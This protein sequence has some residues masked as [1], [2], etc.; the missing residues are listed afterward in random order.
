MVTLQGLSEDVSIIP[1]QL[2]GWVIRRKML[3]EATLPE[4][5]WILVVSADL[6]LRL[7]VHL[8]IRGPCPMSIVC[9]LPLL[10][11]DL[12]TRQFH[13]SLIKEKAIP[14]AKVLDG[15]P[16]IKWNQGSLCLFIPIQSS[17][18]VL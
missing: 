5:P 9:G 14:G 7:A 6:H 4:F 8:L 10:D 3:G 1:V 17:L 16:A 11:P 2:A 15:M 13:E 12:G 18:S